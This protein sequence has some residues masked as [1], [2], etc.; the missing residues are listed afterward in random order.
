[1]RPSPFKRPRFVLGLILAV[2]VVAYAVFGD[3]DLDT[4][5]A[6]QQEK[7]AT[8]CLQGA[9]LEVKSDI[10]PYSRLGS[11]EYT[12]DVDAK[13]DG[14]HLAFVFL[15]DDKESAEQYFDQEKDDAEYDHP[16]K[17]LKIEQRGPDVLRIF[18]DTSEAS[19]IRACVDKAG[20]PPPPPPDK[21]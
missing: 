1:V 17:G 6:D 12:L 14:D 15:F 11:P 9:G 8:A 20:K 13:E 21:K 16:P 7:T 5:D 10:P 4:P 3:L 19:K 18:I 2:A